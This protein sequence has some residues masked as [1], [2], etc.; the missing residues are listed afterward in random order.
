MTFVAPMSRL[1]TL[2][3]LAACAG[4]PMVG[5]PQALAGRPLP[6][7]LTLTFDSSHFGRPAAGVVVRLEGRAR[8]TSEGPMARLVL[9][10]IDSTLER[11]YAER[12]ASARAYRMA[13]TM[14]AAY[15]QLGRCADTTGLRARFAPPSDGAARYAPTWA[16][17]QELPG[18]TTILLRWGAGTYQEF[19]TLTPEGGRLIGETMLLGWPY[20]FPPR[21][22]SGPDWAVVTAAPL[23]C[24]QERAGAA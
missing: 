9:V 16:V 7:C 20:T 17:W 2:A 23:A 3:F 6:A 14:I 8:Q 24:P 21:H 11:D 19:L 5:S 4:A 22:S 15:C 1:A 10:T 13:D 12:A 18:A